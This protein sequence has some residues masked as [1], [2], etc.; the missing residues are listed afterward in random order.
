LRESNN[1]RELPT[2]AV[3]VYN[4]MAM[5]R[6]LLVTEAREGELVGAFLRQGGHHPALASSPKEAL[7]MAGQQPPDLVLVELKEKGTPGWPS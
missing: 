1:H 5:A 4:G 6:V 3:Y 2:G 7:E